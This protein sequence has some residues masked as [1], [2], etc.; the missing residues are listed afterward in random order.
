MGTDLFG[1]SAGEKEYVS[2]E[3]IAKYKKSII[4][5]VQEYLKD[6][7]GYETID[8]L[9]IGTYAQNL[10]DYHVYS[11]T[12]EHEGSFIN[13][14]GKKEP[15]PAISTRQKAFDNFMKL[16]KELGILTLGRKRA[17]SDD[18]GGTKDDDEFSEFD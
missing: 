18:Q 8:D 3:Q 16:A 14:K 1:N 6:R 5:D 15:H 7:G 11:K 9:L 13:N 12:L 2:K 4:K 17:F 10:T